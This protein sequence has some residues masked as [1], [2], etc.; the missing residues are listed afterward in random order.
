MP[1]LNPA[2]IVT[3]SPMLATS[4]QVRRRA[5]AVNPENGRT[6]ESD[7]LVPRAGGIVTPVGNNGQE[8]GDD[9]A[10]GFTTYSVIT[11]YPLRKEA[12][13]VLPDIVLWRGK[14]LV[15]T[16]V[17]DYLAFGDGWV[18]ATCTSQKIADRP[19]GAR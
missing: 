14:H 7:T 10:Y 6:Q 8:R 4:F 15:V 16:D 1:L 13:G 2:L 19:I 18:E 5:Q 17:V 12:E 9:G 11:R 3:T